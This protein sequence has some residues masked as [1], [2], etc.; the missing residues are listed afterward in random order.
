MKAAVLEVLNQPL[1]MHQHW[2][3]PQPGPRDAIIRV[4]ANGIC[5]RDWHIWVGDWA[6]GLTLSLPR[7]I[8]RVLR[9]GGRG[10]SAGHAIH[11]RGPG[12]M[13]L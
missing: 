7:V 9:G 5:R 10:R 13:P 8:G 12:G 2:P 6:W 11:P 1:V 4:E 3:D